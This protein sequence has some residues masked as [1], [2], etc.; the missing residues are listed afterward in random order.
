MRPVS[1]KPLPSKAPVGRRVRVYRNL[2]NGLW[3][4]MAW[5][6]P[7]KGRIIA[8][9]P[10]IYLTVVK[11]V[12][13]PA[14]RE[15]VRREK[16]KNVHAFVEGKVAREP[17]KTQSDRLGWSWNGFFWYNPY[18]CKTFMKYDPNQSKRSTPIHDAHMVRMDKNDC[19]LYERIRLPVPTSGIIYTGGSH[20]QT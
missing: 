16:R 6:G 13:Q 18:R 19:S 2:H 5:D 8:H 17:K 15:K 12:V 20:D 1:S 11:F 9:V 14:G 3:S 10:E 4:V 7:E